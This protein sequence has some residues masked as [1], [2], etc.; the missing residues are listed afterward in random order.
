[1]DLTSAD[2]PPPVD[3]LVDRLERDLAVTT[4]VLINWTQRTTLAPE[5]PEQATLAETRRR[6]AQVAADWAGDHP[7]TTV[8]DVSWDGEVV[9][10]ELTGPEP[11]DT[12]GLAD[13]LADE[14]DEDAEVQIW[15]V[16]RLLL[17]PSGG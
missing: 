6:L 3:D 16:P 12:D 4:P 5:D 7:G 17:T 10:A 14:V 1:V 8:V 2:P 11:G 9:A 13:A 15:F